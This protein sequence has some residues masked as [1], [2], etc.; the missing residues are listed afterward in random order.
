M[1]QVPPQCYAAASPRHLNIQHHDLIFHAKSQCLRTHNQLL[2]LNKYTMIFFNFIFIQKWWED[3]LTGE[4][5][6][7]ILKK[8][9]SSIISEEKDIHLLQHTSNSHVNR[10]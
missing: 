1:Q 9:K 4:D 8:S 2:N 6:R 5:K 7:K 10:T 3:C